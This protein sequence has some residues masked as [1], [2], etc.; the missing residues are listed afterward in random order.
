[1]LKLLLVLFCCILQVCDGI[2]TGYGV[3]NSAVGTEAEG[4]PIVKFMMDFLGVFGGLSLVKL[5][6]ILVIVY[7]YRIQTPT[8]V[9]VAISTIY[10]FVCIS[11]VIILVFGFLV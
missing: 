7:L 8:A 11:W 10:F 4:N 1:M 9:F 5:L 6:A 3:T 2:L